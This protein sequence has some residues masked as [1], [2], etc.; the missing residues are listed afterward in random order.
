M[1]GI[2][3]AVDELKSLPHQDL[4]LAMRHEAMVEMTEA[5]DQLMVAMAEMI[6]TFSAHE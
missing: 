1:S 5:S 3:S 6:R 4:T 2:R